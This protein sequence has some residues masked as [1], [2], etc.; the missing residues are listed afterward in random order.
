MLQKR[1]YQYR[2]YPTAAQQQ[3][4]ART[5]G[6]VRYVYN[7]AL[8]LRIDTYH[9]EKRSLSTNE[10]SARLTVLKQ[11][12]ETP[13]LNE[14]SCVPPQQALRHLAEAFTNFFEGRAA[15]PKFKDR[16]DKQS[17][18]YTR[19][20]FTWDGNVLRLAKMEDPLDVRWSR[21]LPQGARLT[22]V[23]V[24]K[25]TAGRYFVSIVVEEDIAPSSPVNKVV[26][27]DLGLKSM[28]VTS[29]GEAIGNPKFFAREEKKLARA[30]RRL[31]KKKKGSRNREKARRKVARIHARIADRR[32][33]YQQ[34]LSTRMIRE[35]QTICV[36]SLHVKN[37]VKNHCL[38]KS[39]HD[40]GWGEFVRQL[41]YKAAWYGRTLI[42]IDTFFPSSKRCFDCGHVLDDL[43]LEVREW[44]CPECGV[45]HD[46][47]L[48]AANNVLA[49]G[50]S[51]AA[52]GETAR[53]G[54]AQ[55]QK[56]KPRR[57]RKALP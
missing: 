44:T 42:K 18:E 41:E 14:V 31:S 56:G 33:N 5:F 1:A 16:H 38:A 45:H 9:A 6:C 54:R 25:D 29:D 13:F 48:N 39:I 40:V 23:T 11:Q 19:S 35:N 36:E 51:V 57:S 55:A 10:L 53:P 24:S 32:R 28:V 7:W 43:P 8:R 12:P 4:L 17:A 22:T 49:E 30:Q 46:R 15:Y 2:F 52:C 47:D 20:A 34:Q 37:L 3:I 27:L 21:P 50:L 26:G